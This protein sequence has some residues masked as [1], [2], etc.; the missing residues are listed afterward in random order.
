MQARFDL[1]LNDQSEIM[2]MTSSVVSFKL[3]WPDCCLKLITMTLITLQSGYFCLNVLSLWPCD[4]S[5]YDLYNSDNSD[6]KDF[7]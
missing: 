7:E 6:C 5:D 3:I 2:S 4:P 1:L